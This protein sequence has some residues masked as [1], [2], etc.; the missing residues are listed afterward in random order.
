MENIYK[1]MADS[2]IDLQTDNESRQCSI[3]IKN[4]LITVYHMF[5]YSNMWTCCAWMY[6]IYNIY[7]MFKTEFES[8]PF[9]ILLRYER[10]KTTNN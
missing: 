6:N 7:V 4:E 9:Q 10:V 8:D 1:V 5:C 3:D 2:Y